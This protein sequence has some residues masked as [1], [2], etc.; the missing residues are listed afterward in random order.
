MSDKE[1]AGMAN[2]LTAALSG[3]KVLD[4]TEE[5]GLYAGKIL[6]D[7]GADVTLIE[8]PGG[9][10]A[11]QTSPYK[12]DV[13][14]VENSLHFLYFNTNKRGITLALDMPA[15]R[16]IFKKLVKNADVVIEDG[17]VGRMQSIGLGYPVLRKMNG[18]IIV[19][20]VTGFGQ[21]GPYRNY[22][23]P[24]IVNFAMSGIMNTS[25]PADKPPVVAPSVQSYYCSSIVAVYGIIGALFSRT[26][27]GKGQF[28]DVSAHEILAHFAGDGLW[29]YSNISNIPQRMGSQF[30]A[31]PGRIYPCKNGYVHIVILGPN[32]WQPF[33][34]LMRME[35]PGANVL[36]GEEWNDGFFRNQNVDIVDACVLEFTMKHE[37]MELAELCQA[38][39]IPVTPV[40]SP[41]DFSRDSHIIER[42]M[43]VEIEHPV[44]GRH[45]YL[46][47]PYR[48]SKTPCSIRR[49]APVLG[50]H[51]QE[52][53]CGELG[54][55]SEK[56]AKLRDE[57]I[58]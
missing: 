27:T 5:M 40:N 29:S 36:G 45:S 1:T 24:D 33:V 16:D 51:N 34:E 37:K 50:E 20:S 11:R 42:G 48:L 39:G 6:A 26:S 41:L 43:I 10:K 12:D 22:K 8:K 58:I 31:V 57:G 47:P 53:Y 17:E 4:L 3:I 54:Y 56:L 52:V 28:I 32:H 25:G 19:A 15:G 23:A 46:S 14:G 21:T 38:K 44:I 55:S 35:N 49:P 18:G 2:N 9:S 13:P 7:F 30:G